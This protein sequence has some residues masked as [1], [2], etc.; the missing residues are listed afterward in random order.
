M[1][2]SPNPSLALELASFHF[3]KPD[4]NKKLIIFLSKQNVLKQF[5]FSRENTNFPSVVNYWFSMLSHGFF[6]FKDVIIMA[7]FWFNWH[8]PIEKISKNLKTDEVS[9]PPPRAALYNV[10]KWKL[11]VMINWRWWLTLVFSFYSAFVPVWIKSQSLTSVG[12]D[13]KDPD[14][15]R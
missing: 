15:A 2:L 14:K 9:P 4:I 6:P 13:H 5:N 8:C 10:C 3:H 1:N 11:K 12:F 7:I